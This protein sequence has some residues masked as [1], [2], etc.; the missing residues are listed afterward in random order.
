MLGED[1]QR[2]REAALLMHEINLGA[3]AIGTGINADPSTRRSPCR[4][5]AEHHRHCRWSRRR[6]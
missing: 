6:T 4:N 1:E 5:L 3:T 2:L